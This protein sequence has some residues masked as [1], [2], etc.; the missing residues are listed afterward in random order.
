MQLVHVVEL[1]SLF[2]LILLTGTV[3]LG[4]P[5]KPAFLFDEMFQVRLVATELTSFTLYFVVVYRA[6]Y[7]GANHSK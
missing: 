1:M 6:F 3:F 4:W 5:Q 2:T 7:R